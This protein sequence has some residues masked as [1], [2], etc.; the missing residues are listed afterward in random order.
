VTHTRNISSYNVHL[1][2][3]TGD[4][5]FSI[6]ELDFLDAQLST[7]SI[8]DSALHNSDGTLNTKT[9]HRKSKV[10]FL[11]T[12]QNE[13][14]WILDKVSMAFDSFNNEFFHFDI[15]GYEFAQYAEYRAEDGGHYNWHMDLAMGLAPYQ[16]A[17]HSGMHRKLSMSI[18]LNE[19][20]LGGEFQ[21]TLNGGISE[22]TIP[23]RRGSVLVFPSFVCHR[24]K[25]VT[26]G[27]RK[28]LVVWMLG[29]RFR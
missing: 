12:E 20:F 25:P 29:S 28:S 6:E 22:M 27:V 26:S 15:Y 23:L 24:V 18:L 10:A 9:D 11:K 21:I 16:L 13:F 14:A 7:V 3:A 1:P 4:D 19:D 17:G 2:Y 5:L 8:Q